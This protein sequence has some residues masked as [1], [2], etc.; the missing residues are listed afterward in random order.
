M[1][2]S[3]SSSASSTLDTSVAVTALASAVM[4]CTSNVS[5]GQS[6]NISG[7]NISV[8]DSSQTQTVTF[9]TSCTQTADNIANLQ[10]TVANALIQSTNTQTQ[11]VLSSL[12]AASSS[13]INSYIKN[14][15]KQNITQQ[16][17][18]NIVSNLASEQNM[19][20]TGN[21]IVI[22]NFTQSQAM[23]AVI[24]NC[25]TA[26]NNLQS[27]QAINN[28]IQQDAKN[29]QTNPISDILNSIFS[30]LA[31]FGWIW[32]AIIALVVVGIVAIGPQQLLAMFTGSSQG[33]QYSEQQPINYEQQPIN[34]Q[35]QPVNYGP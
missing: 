11:A 27:V 29:T 6:L 25:Q 23:T 10:Q 7:N 33:D 28:A 21:N 15:V 5:A 32:V 18:Q 19:N 30:G 34:Y 2:G 9:N 12:S 3:T 1:G 8:L 31:S 22:K 35:Q 13:D 17:I 4:N 26:I 14:D 20:L 24:T 16:T